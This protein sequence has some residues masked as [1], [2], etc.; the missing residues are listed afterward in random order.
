MIIIQ[1]LRL[2][3][4]FNFK[5]SLYGSSMAFFSISMNNG[6]NCT[7]ID[8]A[9]VFRSKYWEFDI[10]TFVYDLEITSLIKSTN[11]IQQNLRKFCMY[12]VQWRPLRQ[13]PR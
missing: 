12:I 1:L 8:E 10:E 3:M 11:D 13:Y 4:T 9:D 7:I 5:R 6:E 2:I